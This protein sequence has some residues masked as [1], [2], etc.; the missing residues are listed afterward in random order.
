MDT[1]QTKK[2][3]LSK[4]VGLFSSFILYFCLGLILDLSLTYVIPDG[5]IRPLFAVTIPLIL[6]SVILK[7]TDFNDYMITGFLF[8]YAVIFL[9]LLSAFYSSFFNL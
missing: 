5:P 9:P 2:Y 8:F 3:N 4:V 6:A 7:M 1:G